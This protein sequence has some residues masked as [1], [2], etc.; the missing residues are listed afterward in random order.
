MLRCDT[1][2]ASFAPSSLRLFYFPSHRFS[3]WPDDALEAVAMKFLKDVEL[4]QQ[5]REQVRVQGVGPCL[6]LPLLR[7]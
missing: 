2:C 3:A 4:Q 7:G 1:L 6:C 5:Q